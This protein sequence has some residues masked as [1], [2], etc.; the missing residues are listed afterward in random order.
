MPTL[1]QQLNAQMAEAFSAAGLDTAHAVVLP[2]QRPD[3]GQFQC[4]GALAAAK[5]AKGNPRALAEK[6]LAALQGKPGLRDLSL[7]GPGFINLSLTDEALAAHG[8]AQARDSR[9]GL[10]LPAKPQV[11]IV[12][13]G[14]PNVAK[15]MHVGHLRS[16]IIG[17]CIQRLQRRLGHSVLSDVHLGDWG[18]QMGMLI[19][20]VREEQPGLPY[21]IPEEKKG[22]IPSRA[23]SAWTT[24]SG[25]T[26]PCR[27]AARRTRRWPR[28]PAWP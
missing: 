21:F 11:V 25:F 27:P 12:D 14:G 1:L 26:P 24:W 5:A 8:A 4:N 2:S 6:V 19:E 20:A 15:P 10:P 28:R 18:T 23:R 17:D 3:L 13:F 22:P 16:S 9:L 7:A